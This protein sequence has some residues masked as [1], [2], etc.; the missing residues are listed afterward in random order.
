MGVRKE[1]SAGGVVVRQED[2]KYLVAL[3]KTEHK[4]GLVWVLPKGHVE[5]AAKERVPDAA[6]R[7][8]EEEAGVSDLQ[9]RNQLGVTRFRFQAE[10]AVVHKTVHYYLMTTNQKELTPQEEE[11][12]LEA[13]WFPIAEAIQALEY[14]TDQDIVQRAWDSL[15]G[16]PR[17]R[18]KPPRR[19]GRRQ[20]R[21]RT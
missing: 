9:V 21:I 16:R 19:G 14:D 20:V 3:L 2:G 10:T 18:Q 4:R 15:E 1:L 11:G 5:L 8:V 13:K 7:E 12:L 6:K 17:T